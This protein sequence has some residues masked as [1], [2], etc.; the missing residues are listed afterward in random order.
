MLSRR[1]I[2]VICLVVAGVP[3]AV[4]LSCAG[5]RYAVYCGCLVKVLRA[6]ERLSSA[7]VTPATRDL[8]SHLR[9]LRSRLA[10]GWLYAKRDLFLG[11]LRREVGRV[12]DGVSAGAGAAP[13]G[14]GHRVIVTV[15]RLDGAELPGPWALTTVNGSIA[16]RLPA[17]VD[18]DVSAALVNGVMSSDYPLTETSPGEWHGTI[19]SGGRELDMN[20]VNGSIELKSGG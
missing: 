12:S 14:S 6:Q 18:A 3:A 8:R 7:P 2:V 10:R 13:A 16:A 20:T 4:G 11:K 19:G 9:Y 5:V 15:S 17:T 1:K